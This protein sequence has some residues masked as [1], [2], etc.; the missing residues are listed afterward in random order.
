[1]RVASRR[2]RRVDRFRSGRARAGA[3][4]TIV[5]VARVVGPG[6]G[7]GRR[8][9]G[10]ARAAGGRVPRSSRRSATTP[11]GAR[12]STSS[13]SLACAVDVAWRRGRAAPRVLL[14][15]TA[16]G[17]GR[18][19]SLAEKLPA[20]AATS[21][22]PGTRSPGFDARV[23]HRRRRGRAARG[24][25]GAR[26]SSRPRESSRRCARPGS[27]ST[28]SSAARAIPTRPTTARSLA[29]A[30]AGRHHRG[31]RR[32]AGSSPADA[33]RPRRCRGRSRTPTARATRSPR[34][35]TFALGR[36]PLTRRCGRIRRPRR[37][38]AAHAPRRAAVP[39]HT[40][41]REWDAVLR[42]GPIVG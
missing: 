9:G 38:R 17:S 2:P 27:S 16:T 15:S 19:P 35:L 25:R 34:A 23:L 31:R 10:R 29:A 8:R 18:S 6:R 4:A 22:S 42:C 20:R 36:G 28:R 26:R 30:A 14:T 3:R 33:A 5:V 7:R 21:R 13:R 1:M 12:P 41:H 11:S 40:Q 37:R 24:A 32:V 39:N